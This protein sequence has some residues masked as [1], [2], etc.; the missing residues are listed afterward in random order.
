[1]NIEEI[2]KRSCSL[3]NRSEIALIGTL[4]DD[5]YP[6]IKA[7][8]NLL[9]EGLDTLWFSTNT[10]SKRVQ[11]IIKNNKG[12]VYYVDEK[13][14]EG[15]MLIGEFEVL[16]DYESRKK[17]WRN[18]FEKYYPEGINDPDYSVLIFKTKKCNYYQG[19]NNYTFYL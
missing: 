15:L 3:I 12:S 1:M 7:M 18:G 13:T 16:N 4:D 6:N 9:P 17:L 2:K 11:Q 8:L 5:N 14:F 19:L 10:S